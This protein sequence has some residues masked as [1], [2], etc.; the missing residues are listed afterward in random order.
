[1]IRTV[2][3]EDSVMAQNY[4]SDMLAK[5][6]DFQILGVYSD[7]FEAETFC[8][9]DRVDL[10]LMD[11]MTR[12]NH[13]GLAAGR[14]IREKGKDI[15]VVIVTSLIDPDILSS[16][17][18]GAANSLWYK[19]HGAEDLMRVIRLT[20]AGERI[21]PD[22]APS[23]ALGEMFSGDL[24]PRQMQV[25]RRFVTGMT[26]DEIAAE[27]NLSKRGVRWYMDEI[28]KMG[29]FHNRH[30]MLSAILQNNFIVTTLLDSEKE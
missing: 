8:A 10:V 3:V 25:L 11:V 28:M 26:Y 13:S 22:A 7:A 30:E 29:E 19:D 9:P 18:A 15:K 23:V 16:A 5:E 2:I 17:K 21:F 12:N 20:L 6:G 1:M 27:L 4:F 24:S 14:R